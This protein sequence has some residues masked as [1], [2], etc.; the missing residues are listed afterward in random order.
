[1]AEPLALWHADHVVFARLLDLLDAQVEAFHA[2]ERPNYELMTDVVDY[3]QQ[4]G[5]RFH[6]PR[7]DAAFLRL[8]ERDPLMRLP[9]NR[10]LQE[11]RVIARAGE[12]L[13]E[14]LGE[15]AD[16]V[17]TE[18]AAVEMAAATYLVY[19]RHH[20]STEETKVMPRAKEVMT[21]DDWAAAAEAMNAG[22]DPLSP[23]DFNERYRE[24]RK[25]IAL[26]PPRSR[27]G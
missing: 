19:Y 20:M 26:H 16:D 5:D 7:E 3:L 14:R 15:I 13:L 10:L 21:P 9:V 23:A 4:Y 6:H 17:M 11:H 24:L 22:P 1:M 12:E 27:E 2:G 8:V 25:F 18:R